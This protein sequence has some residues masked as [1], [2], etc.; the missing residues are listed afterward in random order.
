MTNE[1]AKLEAIKKA[2]GGENWSILS[3]RIDKKGW[4]H[5]DFIHDPVSSK[6]C[7]F[8]NQ[9]FRPKSLQGIEENNGW[10]RIEPDGSN[11]P[12][13]DGTYRWVDKAGEIVNNYYRNDPQYKSYGDYYTHYKLIIPEPKPIY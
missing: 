13:E 8:R 6:D 7:E 1:Q 4:C 11:L 10:T 2:W 12:V 5:V 9:L 3:N